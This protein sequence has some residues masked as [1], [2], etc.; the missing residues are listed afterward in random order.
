MTPHSLVRLLGVGLLAIAATAFA[1]CGDDDDDGDTTPTGGNS[2]AAGGSP[3]GGGNEGSVIVLGIWGDEELASFEA[4]VEGWGGEVD[5]TGTR[6]ITA[7]LTTR[8]E[9][10]NP[11]DVA[12]PAEIGLFQEFARAGELTPLSE[13]EGLDEYVRANYPESFIELGTVDGTLYGFFM[14]AD[15]KATIFYDPQFFTE[16]NLEPLTADSTFDDLIA[17]SNSIRDAGTPPWSMGQEAGA[18]S[19]FP[20]SDTIQQ[21]VLNEA[22][23]EFYDNVVSGEASFADAEMQDAWEKFGQIALT[24]GYTAQG[25]AAGINATA[26]MDSSYLPF[27]DPPQAGMVH[28]GGFAAGFVSEQFPDA[29][30]GEDYDFMPWPGGRVTGGANIAYA[31]NSDPATCS[32]MTHLAGADAQRIWV[33]RGGFTSVNELVDLEAYPDEV[34]RAQAEQLL[35][36]ETFRFDLDDAIGGALQQAEFQGITQFLTNPDGL[37]GILQNIEAARGQPAPTPAAE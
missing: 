18:G 29:A 9:G 3:S 23:E 13:C 10:G 8:V 33:E 6:D 21:I 17:L 2:P 19:G 35:E 37:E 5:F 4:M 20:G 22:G 26:F 1:A 14:K 32:F 16:N 36:A 30:P 15:T 31:F 25:G 24:D 28:L 7:L 11:P 27:Q 12:V 34:A